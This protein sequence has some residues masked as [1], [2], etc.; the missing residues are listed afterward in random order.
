MAGWIE[1]ETEI[2]RP[3]RLD[4]FEKAYQSRWGT[5]HDD[6]ADAK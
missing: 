4:P 5:M 3:R 1:G 6:N 2:Q